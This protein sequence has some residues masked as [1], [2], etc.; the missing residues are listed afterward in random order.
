MKKVGTVYDE[1]MKIEPRKTSGKK[2][3]GI[4]GSER[5]ENLR[6]ESRWRG[7]RKRGSGKEEKGG[8]E[9][10]NKAIEKKG[11]KRKR[12]NKAGYTAQDA[13]SMRTYHLRK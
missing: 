12:G 7:R 5:K 13:P 9:Q 6:M 1:R 10:E 4:G 3:G 11:G 8:Y 2:R